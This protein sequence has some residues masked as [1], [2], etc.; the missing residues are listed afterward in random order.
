MITTTSGSGTSN[1]K[2]FSPKNVTMA[3]KRSALV[4]VDEGMI[5]REAEAVGGGERCELCIA[6]IVAIARPSERG[7]KRTFVAQT[8][9][10]AKLRELLIANSNDLF[11]GEP[12][13]LRHLAS[14]RSAF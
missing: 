6:V 2:S 3:R 13:R 12:H 10:A 7:L 9:S 1:S 8:G 4:A 14:S 5:T 11:V